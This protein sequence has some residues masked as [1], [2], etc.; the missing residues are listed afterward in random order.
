LDRRADGSYLR[1]QA[2]DLRL[3]LLDLLLLVSDKSLL[4][5]RRF[6][7]QRGEAAVIDALSVLTVLVPGDNLRHNGADFLRDDADF[8]LAV[9]LQVIRNATGL[10][11][12][13]QRSMQSLNIVLPPTR[14]I[15]VPSVA[16]GVTCALSDG[17][18]IR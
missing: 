2:G 5:L 12:L 13:V 17:E 3:L 10:L 7:Q 9:R 1:G 15:C 6:D 11:N 8:V 14:T 16:D 4:F 18:N